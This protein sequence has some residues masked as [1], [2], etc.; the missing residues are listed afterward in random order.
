M[1]RVFAVGVSICAL[2]FSV[3]HARQ[4]APTPPPKPLVPAATNS[5]AAN[6]ESFYGQ[7]VTVTAAVERIVS[8]TS[9]TVDQDPKKSVDE[10][11]VLVDVLNAP[12]ELNT[13]VTVIGEVVRH[14][15]RPAIRAVSVLTSAMVDIAKRLPP[16]MTPDEAL[17]DKAMKRIG[18]AFNS[19]RQAVAASAGDTA[20]DDAIAMKAAF[21]EAESFF[22]KRD[23]PDAQKWAADARGQADILAQSIAAAKWD[24]AKAAASALQQTCSN[25]HGAYRER[26]DDGS[27]RFRTEK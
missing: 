17:L 22:K 23:K 19:V 24:E 27:Y 4:G 9:F 10:V 8:P 7:N 16:P 15:G 1:G 12:L 2:V 5:I 20:K 3:A 14:E 25:C 13:Y 18:P 21:T 6:P 11:L 26:L